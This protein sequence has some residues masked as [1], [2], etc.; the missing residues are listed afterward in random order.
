MQKQEPE[1]KTGQA[2]VTQAD[3]PEQERKWHRSGDG[4]Q[5]GWHKFVISDTKEL[6]KEGHGFKVSLG[7][8]AKPNCKRESKKSWHCSPEVE[9]LH[10]VHKALSSALSSEK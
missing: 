7:Y 3:T 1:L 4:S 9:C 8:T 5:A 2:G 10:R 6:R